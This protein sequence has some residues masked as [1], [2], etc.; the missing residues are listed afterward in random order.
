MRRRTFLATGGTALAAMAGCTSDGGGNG[1]DGSGSGGSGGN[2]G[3]GNGGGANDGDG[4]GGGDGTALADAA[5]ARDLGEQPSLGPAPMEAE[6]V[7]IEVTDPSCPTCRSFHNQAFPK[8]KSEL[9]D[10]GTTAFVA[11][12]V[13]W[14][15]QWAG[16]ASAALEAVHDRS[17]DA[18]WDL[19]DVYF[20]RQR[21][22]D[23]D[24]VLSR[25][26]SH[27]GDTDVDG[28]AVV[29]AVEAG[30]YDDAVSADESAAEDAGAQGQ[31]YFFLFK[32]GE[33]RT[34]FSG[35]QSY[36]VFRSSL[37]Y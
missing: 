9:I 25:T 7:V 14:V 16:Q 5:I 8:L 15:Y 37:G 35:A 24:S 29:E 31:P 26:E 22:L 18:Y 4:N 33:L 30:E 6:S 3:G 10:P 19:L 20:G 34:S 17:P 2:G 27:L 32:N 23:A 36:D 28:A 11:R 1:G 21:S 12:N 13:S